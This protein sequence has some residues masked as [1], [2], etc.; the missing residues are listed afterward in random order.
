MPIPREII[1]SL[2]SILGIF[3]SDIRHRTRAAFILCDEMV[4]MTCKLRAREANHRFDMSAN[5]HNSITAPG[6]SPLPA[7]LESSIRG[8]RNTM[9]T[10]QHASAAVTVDDQ[11]CADAFLDAIQVIDH[12]WPISSSVVFPLWIKC[13]IRVV[14]LYSGQGNPRQRVDFEDRMRDSS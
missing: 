4:E 13:A 12:C 11:H 3:F 2:E 1:D 14:R 10:M 6:V 8:N 9:N 7:P 5:F